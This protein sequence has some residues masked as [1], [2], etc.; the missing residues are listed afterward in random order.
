MK[1]FFPKQIYSAPSE[2]RIREI[3]IPPVTPGVI[4]I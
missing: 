3:A 4:K 1:G 2:L